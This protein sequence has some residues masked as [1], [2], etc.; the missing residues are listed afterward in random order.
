MKK[1]RMKELQKDIKKKRVIYEVGLAN[2]RNYPCREFVKHRGILI[3]IKIIKKKTQ[4]K[5][6]RNSSVR[7]SFS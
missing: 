1:K 3:K 6:V 7:I 2:S 4:S 5:L